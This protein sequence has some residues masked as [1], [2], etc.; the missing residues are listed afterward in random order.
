MDANVLYKPSAFKHETRL[1]DILWAIETAMYDELM[2]GYEN[3]HLLLGFDVHG[4]PLEIMYN[5]LGDDTISVFH[6][7]ACRAAFIPLM[8]P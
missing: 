1:E 3:K 7:M 6:A 2:E 8:N 5:D 4:N